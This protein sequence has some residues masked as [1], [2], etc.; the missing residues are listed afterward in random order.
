MKF[1]KHNHS[2][3]PDAL[4]Q[5]AAGLKLLAQQLKQLNSRIKVPTVYAVDHHT[6]T[7]S[8]INQQTPQSAQWQTLGQALAELHQVAQKHCGHQSNNYIGLNPQSNVIS[9]NWGEF[10]YQ[11]RLEFQVNLIQDPNTCQQFN[12]T[13]TALRE[14]LIEFLNQNC[15]HPSLLHGDLWS[16]NVLF[17]ATD[18]WLIDPAVYCGDADADLAMTELFGGFPSSFYHAYTTQRPLS[19]DYGIKKTIYNLYHQLNHYNLFGSGYL[20]SCDHA[21]STMSQFFD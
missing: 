16:G 14:P 2:N 17:D 1:S 3:Y 15:P 13:L 4:Q 20:G 7:L 19:A 8:H 6:L 9:D 18:V 5:E 10:F 11:Y 12:S 21:L